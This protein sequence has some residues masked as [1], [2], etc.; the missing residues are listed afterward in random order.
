MY[1]FSTG[2]SIMWI[3][4]SP[5]SPSFCAIVLLGLYLVQLSKTSLLMHSVY[6]F[7]QS[8]SVLFTFV[9]HS[10]VEAAKK[11]RVAAWSK[12]KHR[13]L[14]MCVMLMVFFRNRTSTHI[15]II[16]KCTNSSIQCY[17]QQNNIHLLSNSNLT[18]IDMPCNSKIKRK[19]L[20]KF[21]YVPL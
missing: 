8:K 16:H 3:N 5:Y 18:S 14:C 9:G 13:L 10:S 6:I 15:L 20:A 11:E 2:L 19:K 12:K 21:K 17:R 7:S 4:N 1:E